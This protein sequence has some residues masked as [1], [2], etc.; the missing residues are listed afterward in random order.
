MIDYRAL[1]NARGTSKL[2]TGRTKL[3]IDNLIG[4]YP[5]GVTLAAV[6][7]VKGTDSEYA[8]FT[9]KE[10]DTIF[11]NA[12][13]IFTEFINNVIASGVSLDQINADWAQQDFKV[14]FSKCKAQKSNRTYVNFE[15]L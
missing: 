14:K 12:N 4:T 5:D 13:A 9:I 11:V 15:A 3:S 8:V 10:D 7:L 2:Y 6:D 1:A